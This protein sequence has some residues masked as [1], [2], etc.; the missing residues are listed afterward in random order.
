MFVHGEAVKKVD[1]NVTFVKRGFFTTCNLDDPH[2]AFRA[3]KL[4]VINK[5]LAI[6]GPAHP[7]FEGVPITCLPAIWFL[8]AEPG[9]S[10]RIVATAVCH[11]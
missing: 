9:T 3:N 7:E 11:Q 5:K 10:F 8:S 1:E 6:S 4:K 2:F